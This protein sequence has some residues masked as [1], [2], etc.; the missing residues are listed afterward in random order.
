MRAPHCWRACG[1]GASR[2]YRV[3]ETSINKSGES[4]EEEK[5]D[6]IDTSAARRPET[7]AQDICRRLGLLFAASAALKAAAAANKG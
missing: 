4:E 2:N 1:E 7:R 5:A 6:P 3:E